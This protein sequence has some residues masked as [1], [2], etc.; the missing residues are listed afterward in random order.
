MAKMGSCGSAFQGLKFEQRLFLW[1]PEVASAH[2]GGSRQKTWI[3]VFFDHMLRTYRMF[4]FFVM[5]DT[6]FW[7]QP[8]SA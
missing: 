7:A 8:E 3:F 6:K 5:Q 1:R 2:A 4:D